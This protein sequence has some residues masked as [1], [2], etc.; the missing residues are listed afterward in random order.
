MPTPSRDRRRTARR[1]A[2]LPPGVCCLWTEP[3]GQERRI[4]GKLVDGNRAYVEDGVVIARA[5]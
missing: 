3:G 1:Q 2:E 4:M 5:A